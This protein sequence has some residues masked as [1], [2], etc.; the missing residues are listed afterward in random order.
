MP[1]ADTDEPA[2]DGTTQPAVVAH[3]TE[4]GKAP[5]P[6]ASMTPEA[7]SPT[8]L[9]P[10]STITQAKDADGT[11]TIGLKTPPL[12]KTPTVAS[13]PARQQEREPIYRVNQLP[14]STEATGVA[15]KPKRAFA[16]IIELP[17]LIVDL[18]NSKSQDEARDDE[19]ATRGNTSGSGRGGKMGPSLSDVELDVSPAV[20]ELKVPGKYH[21]RL[22]MPCIVDES[23]VTAKF[24][25]SRAVLR[26]LVREK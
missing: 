9:A 21:L 14:P 1:V 5:M 16:V 3:A 11:R 7:L 15:T 10:T 8:V 22:E 24:N 25:K 2:T 6:S 4:V 23:A 12:K 20:L 17:E 13:S 26:V 18:A 19:R